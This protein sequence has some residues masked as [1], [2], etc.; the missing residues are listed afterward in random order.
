MVWHEK[1][2]SERPGEK[3][4]LG[5]NVGKV[6]GEHE[7]GE[8]GNSGFYKCSRS[9]E[10]LGKVKGK[11]MRIC[12]KELMRK[13]LEARVLLQKVVHLLERA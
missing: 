8:V 3:C 1:R 9:T 4:F 5:N 7:E 13:K 2:W 10:M 6:N 12:W 11:D